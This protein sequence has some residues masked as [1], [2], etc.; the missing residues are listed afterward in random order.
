MTA[1]FKSELGFYAVLSGPGAGPRSPLFISQGRAAEWAREQIDRTLREGRTLTYRILVGR[2][3]PYRLADAARD[4]REIRWKITYEE[5]DRPGH[6]FSMV[7]TASNEEE[8]R[9]KFRRSSTAY[10][11]V[12]GVEQTRDAD[13]GSKCPSCGQGFLH[14][15]IN[16]SRGEGGQGRKYETIKLECDRCGYSTKGGYKVDRY[17]MKPRD[18]DT[19]QNVRRVISMLTGRVSEEPVFAEAWYT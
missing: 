11:R 10:T 4:A 5:E 7:V 8:A 2:E 3:D 14:Q 15:Q 13:T 17:G 18:A 6:T 1:D 9:R 19:P 12:R 16:L